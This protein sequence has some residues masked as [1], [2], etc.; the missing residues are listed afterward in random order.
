MKQ[1]F[2]VIVVGAGHAGCEA[3]YA[4]ARLGAHVGLCTLT[5]DTVAHMPC[6]PAI[7]GTAKGH[8]VREIDALGGLMGRAIDATGIQF[9]LLN[10]SRGP[11]VWSPRA[12]A[13]KKIYGKWVAA[14]LEAEPNIEWLIGR[15]GRI[16][17]EHG[18]VTGLAFEDGDSY[19]CRALVI[20]TG[21]FLNGLVHIGPE[22]HPAGRS[23]E[24][25]SRELAASLK[26]FGYQWGRLK[27]GTPPRLDRA[28]IDFDSCVADGRFSLERGDDPPVPFS[29]L[30]GPIDRGQTDCYLLHTNERVRD[31]V[32]AN[33]DRSPLFN[34]QIRGIGP[35]YCPSLEDKIVRFPDKE[36]HQ[37]FLEPEGIEA[38]EIYVNGFSM[39]LPREVQVDLVHALPGLEDA[40][41]LRPGYAVEYDFIQ[42]TELTRRLETKRVAGLFL[43]GQINGTS[44][45]EEAGAQGLVAGANAAYAASFGSGLELRRDEAYIGIL[46]DDLITKGCLEPYRMF[47]SRA[48]HRL[49]LRIDNADLRLTPRGRA[50]GLVDD[51]RWEQ[52]EARRGRFQRNIEMLDSVFVRASSG[53]RVPASQ[54]LRQPE[55]RLSDL[56]AS[57]RL[58]RFEC[59]QRDATLDVSSAETTVKYAGYLRRQESEIARGRKDERRRIPVGFPFDR[60]PGLS[61]EVV[62]RLTQVRPDTLGQ[63]L[64]IP[65]VT[66]AAVAVLG[67][68]VGRFSPAANQ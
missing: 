67:A 48:E 14:A 51:E 46:V 49:L 68:F 4:A 38:R 12:Q 34:G 19:G 29:F 7:G 63:A 35:R 18:R 36:R 20:T 26:S 44:G 2:D 23:G 28:S 24:P 47:T 59:D 15:A 25:P 54:L 42:P 39:S 16:L 11:A 1:G 8:L 13:D 37:I 57:D 65:G 21:T 32:R 3:A 17:A 62:Q 6:N 55:V 50:T 31:V 27:T 52:F 58:P 5:K 22:Q 53:G 61:R 9:K 60:V 33:I 56:L 41:L 45:Y 64:R 10:R 43:A 30:S 66:P 40:V